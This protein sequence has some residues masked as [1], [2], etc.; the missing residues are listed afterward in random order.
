MHEEPT[1]PQ[2][3]P[4]WSVLNSTSGKAVKLAADPESNSFLLIQVKINSA[5]HDKAQQQVPKDRV[6]VSDFILNFTG[7]ANLCVFNPW[8][9]L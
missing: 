1:N 4:S 3:Y 2:N 6:A 8:K 9:F 7:H 5:Y